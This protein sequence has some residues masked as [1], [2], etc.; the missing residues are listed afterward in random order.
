MG[1]RCGIGGC[2][3]L[4]LLQERGGYGGHGFDAGGEGG[5][6]EGFE[7]A[8]VEAGELVAGGVGGG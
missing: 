5:F 3:S 6:G 8:G 7:V 2:G 1:G 4:R